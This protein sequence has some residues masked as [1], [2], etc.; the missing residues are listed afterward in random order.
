[1]QQDVAFYRVIS[2]MLKKL[3]NNLVV[4]EK[5]MPESAKC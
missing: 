4:Y 2:E 1:M 5:I 3:I